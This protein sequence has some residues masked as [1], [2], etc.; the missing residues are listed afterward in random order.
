MNFGGNELL[1]L[2]TLTP[3]QVKRAD[4]FHLEF[5]IAGTDLAAHA[6]ALTGKLKIRWESGLKL[7]VL[8]YG[9]FLIISV[10]P[11]F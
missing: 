9:L 5:V 2:R 4:E 1:Q 10:F 6:G 11:H 3:Q 7:H 8:L